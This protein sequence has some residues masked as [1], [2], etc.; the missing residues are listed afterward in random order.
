[1][2]QAGTPLLFV[3]TMQ[4]TLAALPFTRLLERRDRFVVRLVVAIVAF[5]SLDLIWVRPLVELSTSLPSPLDSLV[6][7]FTFSGLLGFLVLGILFIF[8]CSTWTALFCGSATYA[9]QNVM[10]SL[11]NVVNPLVM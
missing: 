11:P 10:H 4:L 3:I 9:V 6:T 1:M 8:R 5:N 7:V 2:P